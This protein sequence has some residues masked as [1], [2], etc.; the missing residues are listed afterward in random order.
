MGAGTST[1]GE[2]KAGGSRREGGTPLGHKTQVKMHGAWGISSEE[3]A[4]K[5]AGGSTLCNAAAGVMTAAALGVFFKPTHTSKSCCRGS[6]LSCCC[7][8]ARSWYHP[9]MD[10]LPT[11]RLQQLRQP[12]PSYPQ[13]TTTNHTHTD[14]QVPTHTPSLGTKVDTHHEDPTFYP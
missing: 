1:A 14:L 2:G 12:P 4:G 10:K 7:C 3:P 5:H 8:C 11:Q 13:P 6:C 9:W